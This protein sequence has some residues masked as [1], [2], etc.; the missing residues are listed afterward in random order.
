M[1]RL[2]SRIEQLHPSP[3]REILKIIDTP[4]MVSFA[5]GLPA[6][7]S[8]P[9]VSDYVI[10]P[11]MLQYGR[12]EGETQLREQVAEELRDLGIHTTAERVLILSANS[13]TTST[14]SVLAL[15]AAQDTVCIPQGL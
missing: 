10:D 12:S 13:N 4:G 5:G 8:F 15:G 2:S 14:G 1:P 7:S 3:I 6:P 9:D 11:S